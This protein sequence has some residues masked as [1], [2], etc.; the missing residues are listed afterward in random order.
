M[1]SGGG[2][3]RGGGDELCLVL[4]FL[5]WNATLVIIT[6]RPGGSVA[7]GVPEDRL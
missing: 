3:E 6:P 1:N 7:A 2:K 5:S 4:F